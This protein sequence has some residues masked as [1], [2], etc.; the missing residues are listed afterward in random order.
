[1]LQRWAIALAIL[2]LGGC[3]SMNDCRTFT[4][5]PGPESFDL[6]R[7]TNGPRLIIASQQ[8]R[9]KKRPPGSIVAFTI[10]EHKASELKLVGRPADRPAFHP[11]AVSLHGTRAYVLLRH[12]KPRIRA[13]EIYELGATT[14]TWVDAIANG[15]VDGRD[16]LEN[17][18]GLHVASNGTVF[19]SNDSRSTGF[20]NRVEM[21]TRRVHGSLV[22]YANSRW[23]RL[24][25]HLKFG[26]GIVA[27]D[28]FVYI[29]EYYGSRILRFE[30]RPG[31]AT[32]GAMTPIPLP[33]YPD[34]LSWQDANT[35]DV[36]CHPNAIAIGLHLIMPFVKAASE[37]YAL[38][39]RNHHQLEPLYRVPGRVF[40]A[41][42]QA[43]VVGDSVYAG[44]I[45]ESQIM[46]C[47]RK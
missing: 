23:H 36:A 28:E 24:A 1:M 31:D 20:R 38:D 19:V 37:A 12:E 4:V 11:L 26:N 14:L 6:D 18:N 41:G 16:A 45:V 47:P 22:A 15:A 44:Q 35:I 33:C 40:S 29:A 46:V 8:R 10:P 34:N 2:L 27:N 39:I 17:P 32:V 5:T 13:I 30:R 43:L 3:A 9:G 7:G 25:D 21:V 42:S